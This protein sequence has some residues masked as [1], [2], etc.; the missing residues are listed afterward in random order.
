MIC[1]TGKMTLIWHNGSTRRITCPSAN[2]PPQI[3]SGLSWDRSRP[4]AVRGQR[5]TRQE[6]Y[7]DVTWRRVRVRLLPWKSSKY[8]IFRVCVCSLSFPAC[9]ARASY[10]TYFHLWPFWHYHIFTL[11]HFRKML[12]II[13]CV[14]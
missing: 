2:F 9:N 7:C 1:S 5:L 12:L 4:S 11:F 3:S 13:K 8:Y 14:F 6:M 10:Y